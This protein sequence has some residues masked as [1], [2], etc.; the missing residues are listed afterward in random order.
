MNLTTVNPTYNSKF[1]RLKKKNNIY[2]Y[3]CHQNTTNKTDSKKRFVSVSD[4]LMLLLNM[5]LRTELQDLQF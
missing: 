3:V 1:S 2:V 5:L 4:L